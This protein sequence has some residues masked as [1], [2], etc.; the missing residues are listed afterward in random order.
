[1]AHD[2]RKDLHAIGGVQN[3]TAGS[4][5]LSDVPDNV[6]LLPV[7]ISAQDGIASRGFLY[8]L[9]GTRPR[10]GA[11]FMHP[12][13]DQSLNYNIMPLVMA[14]FAVL[15]RAGR[16]ANNDVS[17]LHET[18]LL[19]MAAGIQ[20]LRE[21]GCEQVVL[22]G[23]SGG[24]S[25]AAFYQA[26]A[27][28]K[29]GQRL[30]TTA[31][32]DPFDLNRFNLPA[33]DGVAV[34]GPHIGQGRVLGK[35][36][37]GAVVDERDPL[38]TDPSLDIYD[39]RN[40]FVTPPDSSSYDQGFLS[41]YRQAQSDRVGRLDAI[42]RA[43]I[44]RQRAAAEDEKRL[45]AA[46]SLATVRAA[47]LE[48][49][50]IIHRTVADPA[51]V[52]LSIDPDERTV[53]SYFGAR[54]DMENYAPDGFARYI[55]PRAWLSTWSAHSSR[56]STIDNLSRQSAPLLIVHY[57]GDCG[58]RMGEIRNMFDQS[59]SADKTLRIIE[60]ADHYGF[61]IK[62]DGSRGERVTDGT[63]AIVAWMADRFSPQS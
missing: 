49:H 42:A 1:M 63:A 46:A 50:M 41:R 27:L 54:P 15:G 61:R 56:A 51:F 29:K 12:R 52:D 19:D 59:A 60:G 24:S 10:A 44:E 48:P 37:D 8:R 5:K 3:P 26:Q 21:T 18:L 13:S 57:T 25:L 28:A 7:Q 39:P 43:H 20:L 6:E 36:I 62:P 45:G 30:T 11:H 16:W 58:V 35:M 38:I 9:K 23:N 53:A 14:G 32:G 31:A 17:T 2:I 34:I 33:A 47:R 55:T 22:V 40:G 4:A